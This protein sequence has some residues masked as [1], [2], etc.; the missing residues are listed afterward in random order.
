ML[1]PRSDSENAMISDHLS[2]RTRVSALPKFVPDQKRKIPTP[3]SRE[4]A[5]RR[6]KPFAS[7]AE[8]QIFAAFRL[9]GPA[10]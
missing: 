9:R 2:R 10:V 6:P 4:S 1:K 3:L 8:Q 5:R 7:A